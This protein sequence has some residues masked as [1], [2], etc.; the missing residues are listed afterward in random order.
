MDTASERYFHKLKQHLPLV[1]DPTVVI[2]RGH[3]L[4]EELLD[5]I[6]AAGLRDPSAIMNAKLTFFQKISLAQGMV[7]RAGNDAWK[8][9]KELNKLRN[10]IGHKLP[11]AALSAKMD[12]VLRIL[13]EDEFDQI[14]NDVYSKSKALRKGIIF[15]CAF[16]AGFIEGILAAKNRPLTGTL[17]GDQTN[18]T[19]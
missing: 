4:V 2:L 6:I 18:R 9:I 5:E 13:F 10:E 3:L 15:H 8:P 11:D 1:K 14:P 16:L 7:G 17:T 19:E 12:T